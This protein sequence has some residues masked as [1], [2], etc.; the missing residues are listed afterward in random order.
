MN[1]FRWFSP[2]IQTWRLFRQT[3]WFR[4]T[5]RNVSY[6]QTKIPAYLLDRTVP[7]EEVLKKLTPED[8]ARLQVIEA[9]HRLLVDQGMRVP[10]KLTPRAQLD[11]LCCVSQSA[12]SRYY[13]FAFKK[14][15]KHE[16]ERAKKA[17][18]SISLSPDA[19]PASND[20]IIRVVDSKCVR[21]H[22]E[23][24]MLAEMRC[25]D[26]AQQ[27]VFDFTHESEMRLQ[28]QKNLANQMTYVIQTTRLMKPYP[29]HLTLC[30]LLPHT[31]QYAFMEEEFGVTSPGS[32]IHS[33][34]DLPWTISPNH[35]SV[36][37]PIGNP[38]RPV[39]YL[40][41][42]APRSFEPGEW[43]HNAVYVIGA[44]V[45]KAVRRP[46]TLAKARRTGV[47]CIRL[48]LERYF[49]WSSGSSKTLTINC[50]HAI[51]ATA[52]STNGDWEKALRDNLPRRVY[53]KPERP[54]FQVGRLFAMI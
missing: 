38:S 33:L 35:Y 50:M 36:D 21:A 10:S 29:F 31:N 8:A 6:Q 14:E 22:Q 47:E 53:D 19:S 2:A 1:P 13:L 5:V 49:K 44:I 39:I 32:S 42:N 37:F 24:W 27:L 7:V 41:P 26:S 15:K 52:K 23:S 34:T 11:L 45:D 20:R 3:P 9:E 12:R 18:K 40:S 48:P 46:I 25:P 17:N 54:S 4:C 30:G 43:D 16:N 51:L 28:D